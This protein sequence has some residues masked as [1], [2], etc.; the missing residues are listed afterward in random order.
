MTA[1]LLIS[2]EDLLAKGISFSDAQLWRLIKEGKFPKPLPL[3]TRQRAST[4]WSVSE[5]E[6]RHD[7]Q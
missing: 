2:R 5:T 6:T 4:I 3:G 7:R 1:R